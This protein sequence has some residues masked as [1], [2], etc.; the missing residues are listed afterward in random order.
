MCRRFAFDTYDREIER[1]GGPAGMAVVE[2]IFTADS[3]ATIDLLAVLRRASDLDRLTVAVASIDDLLSA[4]GLDEAQ[5]HAWYRGRVKTL[6]LSGQDFRERKSVLQSWLSGANGAGTIEESVALLGIFAERRRSLASVA[7]R[8][9]A[10]AE[11][12]GLGKPLDVIL[13]SV[14][15]MHCNRLAGGDRDIEERALGFSFE[16]VK[17]SRK[18]RWRPQR[19][20][21]RH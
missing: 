11:G 5:R 7:T 12:A 21:P 3:P 8:F 2:A 6:H 9:A 18:R 20:T 4:I 17:V 14:V 19:P 15:H 1:Y 10:L 16:S 13:Q